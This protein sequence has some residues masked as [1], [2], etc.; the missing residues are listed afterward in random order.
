[1]YVWPEALQGLIKFDL[2]TIMGRRDDGFDSHAPLL[3]A[4]ESDPV[5]STRIMIAEPWDVGPGGYQLGNF[6]PRWY[7]WNDRFRDD[8]RRFWRGDD[9]SLIHI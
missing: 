7:E 5:L 6:P 4:I 2:A 8:V 1:M 3:L 9:L